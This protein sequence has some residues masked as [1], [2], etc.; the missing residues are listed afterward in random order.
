MED[1]ASLEDY[2]R[3]APIDLYGDFEGGGGRADKQLVLIRGWRP[4]QSSKRM[5]C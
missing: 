3:E 2:L 5:P 4:T 1:A